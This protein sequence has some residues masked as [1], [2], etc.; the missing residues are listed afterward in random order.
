VSD[1]AV[2]G[3][4][5]LQA[6]LDTLPAKVEANLLRAAMRKG[7]NVILKEARGNLAASGS[8][9]TGVLAKGL[10]VSTNRSGG[11]VTAS[12]KARGEH[13]YIANWIEYGVAAHGV[14]KGA[15]RSKGTGQDGK[16]HP[17][18]TERPFLRPAMDT[19]A[20]DALLAVGESLKERLATKQGLDTQDIEV[21]IV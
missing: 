8:V 19:R 6:L 14:K 11:T 18:F 13:A 5:D 20:A 16:L 2:T 10:K 17:G 12:V 1:V 3:L 4:S 9:D 21:D 7:A 15:D